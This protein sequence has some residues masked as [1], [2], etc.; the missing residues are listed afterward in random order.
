MER[1]EN[2][3]LLTTKDNKFN[4]FTE[5]DDWKNFDE[6]TKHYCTEAYVARVVAEYALQVRSIL[7]GDVSPSELERLRDKAYDSIINLNNEIGYD[8]YVKVGRDGKRINDS[9]SHYL[10]STPQPA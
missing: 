7:E 5:Y 8:I 2:D 1:T 9:P 3:I 4:P 10:E 6:D